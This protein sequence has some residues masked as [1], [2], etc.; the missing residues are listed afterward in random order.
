MA[1]SWVQEYTWESN[2]Q[3]ILDPDAY[4]GYAGPTGMRFKSIT[5]RK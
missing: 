1:N 5:P 3:T 4:L 2:E